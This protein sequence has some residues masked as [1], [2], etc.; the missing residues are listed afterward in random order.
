MEQQTPPVV[1]QT[2][3][4]QQP[5]PPPPAKKDGSS[6]LLIV[7]IGI[8]LLGLGLVGG[9]FIANQNIGINSDDKKLSPSPSITQNIITPSPTVAPTSSVKTKTV[10]AGLTDST[11]FKPYSIE[12]P[13][14]WTDVRENTQAA[15]ID[16]LT[17]T[18]NGYTLTIYQAAM[19]GGGCLYK[20]DPPSEMAQTFTDF[21]EIMG[22]TETYRRSWNQNA[23][24]TISYNVCTK[25]T[26]GSYSTFSSFG[27][28]SAVSP[29]PADAT[30]LAEIDAMIASLIKQ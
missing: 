19:G 17:L 21:A 23:A 30:I 14:G 10:K 4:P 15:G 6:K 25:G 22:T 29:N 8:I 24:K 7:T 18:K 1:T 3:T 26:D 27:A 12:V 11:A 16:K 13:A 2:Q 20:G 28:I 9:Y 5:A